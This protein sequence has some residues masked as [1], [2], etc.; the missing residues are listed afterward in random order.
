[1]KG[2][3][4]ECKEFGNITIRHKKSFK[5]LK[6]ENLAKIQQYEPNSSKAIFDMRSFKKKCSMK[7]TEKRIKKKSSK[8]LRY[9]EKINENKNKNNNNNNIIN[10]DDKLF[11]DKNH[12]KKNSGIILDKTD[13]KIDNKKPNNLDDKN[14]QDSF[15]KK[16]IENADTLVQIE[17]KNNKKRKKFFCCPFLLCF[18]MSKN[19]GNGDIL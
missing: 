12:H 19:E 5:T 3:I 4:D 16:S 15:H 6:S 1:M 10:N 9:N 8:L 7:F 18:K 11:L 14:N 13:K 2:I 17:H